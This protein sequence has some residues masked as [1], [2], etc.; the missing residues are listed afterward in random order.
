MDDASKKQQDAL[1]IAQN[2]GTSGNSDDGDMDDTDESLDDDMMDKI[3]SSPSIEDGGCNSITIPH[4][5]PRRVD[6]LQAMRDRASPVSPAFSEA[7]SSSP[8]TE[9][10]EYPPTQHSWQHSKASASATSHH[11]LRGEYNE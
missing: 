10:P 7:M 9:T 4:S 6:S 3:S 1:A 5:W 11:H 8:Y 2:G